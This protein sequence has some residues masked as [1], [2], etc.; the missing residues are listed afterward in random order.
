MKS[1][2]NKQSQAVATKKPELQPPQK[3]AVPVAVG[4]DLSATTYLDIL[5]RMKLATNTKSDTA[6]AQ[7]LRVRQSSVSGAKDRQRIPP[8]WAVQIALEYGVSMD[9]LMLGEGEMMRGASAPERPAWESPEK[10][11]LYNGKDT[12]TCFDCELMI[13]LVEARLSAGNGSFE[14]SADSERRYAFRTDFLCRKGNASAMV[15]MRV[16]GDSMEPDIKDNDVVLVDTANTTP[17]P[18]RLYAVAVQDLVYLKKVNATP[19]K[20]ILSSANPAYTP[21]EIDARGDLKNGIRIIGKAVWV[22]RELD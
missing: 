21:L 3:V 14:T 19:D 20:L 10:T 7:A 5:D 4:A 8:A 6:F 2:N 11:G 18:G 22:G 17:L 13:P 9:W 12:L 16:A 1:D 15:L